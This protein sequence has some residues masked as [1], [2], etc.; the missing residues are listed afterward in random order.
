VIAEGD[1]LV[2]DEKGEAIGSNKYQ[3][4]RIKD[5]VN[6]LIPRRLNDHD[7][8]V[9]FVSRYNDECWNFQRNELDTLAKDKVTSLTNAVRQ[10]T[11]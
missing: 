6:L 7:V 9:E 10:G 5:E 3:Q 1:A 4:Q 11:K 2:V 8:Y